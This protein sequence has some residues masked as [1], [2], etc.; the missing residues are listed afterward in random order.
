MT[1][2]NGCSNCRDAQGLGFEITMAFQPIVDI[3]DKTIYGYEALVRGTNG[4]GAGEILS[5]ITEENRYMF[6]QS[7]RTKAIEL[8][9][10][11]GLKAR[12]SINFLPNAVYQPEACIRATLA[13]AEKYNFP[14]SKI[15][16]EVTES[17]PVQDPE[18]LLNIFQSYQNRGFSTAIDDFG[19]GYA[20]LSLLLKFRPQVIKID[21]E[22]CQGIAQDDIKQTITRGIIE[23]ARR[24]D[25]EIVAEG[26]ENEDDLKKLSEMGVYLI[27]GYLFSRPE[28]EALPIPDG[29]IVK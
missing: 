13:A 7:C 17:E 19:A 21:M 15:T 4:E 24:L 20:G 29:F 6:D 9:S 16:F 1:A 3:R 22:L 5:R 25:I 18:H 11:L 27:Q 14:L 23:T 28:V 26:I 2:P 10:K 8:A 12:L